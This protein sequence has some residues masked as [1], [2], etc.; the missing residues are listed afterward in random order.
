MNDFCFLRIRPPPRSTRTDTLFPYTTLFR[1]DLVIDT[2]TPGD[3]IF[4]KVASYQGGQEGRIVQGQAAARWNRGTI[5]QNRPR[6]ANC[7]KAGI[8]RVAT[9]SKATAEPALLLCIPG[10]APYRQLV[11]QFIV[12]AAKDRLGDRPLIVEIVGIVPI[13]DPATVR[14][15]E[16]RQAGEVE[17][18]LRTGIGQVLIFIGRL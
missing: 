5:G 9:I 15:Q 8:R 3:I 18:P 7:I 6:V 12:K 10:R 16:G 14:A 13:I 4:I 2:S 11:R 17:G 1:S